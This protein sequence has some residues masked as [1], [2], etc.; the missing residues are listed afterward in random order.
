M[1]SWALTY[2]LRLR[3]PLGEPLPHYF[4]A[5]HCIALYFTALHFT[6]LDCVRCY[7]GITEVRRD[8]NGG[9]LA[10]LEMEIKKLFQDIS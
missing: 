9:K 4:T 5:L 1:L 2:T 7:G 3:F 6:P 8:G 10:L